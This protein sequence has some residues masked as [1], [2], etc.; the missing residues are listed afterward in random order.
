MRDE[1]LNQSSK[2]L[3]RGSYPSWSENVVHFLHRRYIK[4]R[5]NPVVWVIIDVGIFTPL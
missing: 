1:V 2:S 5:S 4:Y 3:N